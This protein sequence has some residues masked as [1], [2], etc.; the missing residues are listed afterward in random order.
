MA[1]RF[2]VKHASHLLSEE[3]ARLIPAEMVLD[4]LALSKDESFVDVGVGPGYF[5]LPAAKRAA[6]V[7]GVDVEP[8]MLEMVHDRAAEAGLNNIQAVHADAQAIH[9][10][11]AV[12][13]K[14][15][16][17]FVLHEVPSRPQALRELHR[18]MKPSGKLMILEWMAKPMESGPP[19]HERL[20][21]T[22][23]EQDL[24]DAGFKVQETWY[25]N[26]QHFA[27]IAQK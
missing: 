19:L 3:R 23:V 4:K 24:R 10:E 13:E 5:A 22:Q 25:P 17:A 21:E 2:D 27:V 9:V 20:S 18:L 12:A 11:D 15:L 14:A 7:Y 1:H 8:K 26:E 6:K 16:M